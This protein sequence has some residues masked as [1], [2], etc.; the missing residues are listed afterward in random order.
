MENV[1][2]WEFGRPFVKYDDGTDVLSDETRAQLDRRE[3]ALTAKEREKA[4]A[5]LVGRQTIP[6]R[7]DSCSGARKG[8]RAASAADQPQAA[9]THRLPRRIGTRNPFCG[10]LTDRH[11]ASRDGAYV[12]DLCHALLGVLQRCTREW[13]GIAAARTVLRRL[14]SAP[15]V[16]E[17]TPSSVDRP[18]ETHGIDVQARSGGPDT[19]GSVSCR[20]SRRGLPMGAGPWC[21]SSSCRTGTLRTVSG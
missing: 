3:A 12:R 21:L 6:T 1:R 10:D 16:V 8:S 11:L 17:R 18:L 13:P 5:D 19:S 14:R 20:V 15:S 4:V 2:D 9:I 7:Y